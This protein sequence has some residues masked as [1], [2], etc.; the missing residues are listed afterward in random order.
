MDSGEH[1]C[2]LLRLCVLG[3]IFVRLVDTALCDAVQ[4]L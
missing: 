1:W 4:I 3:S 2:G